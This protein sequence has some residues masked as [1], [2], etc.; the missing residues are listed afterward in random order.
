MPV[1]VASFLVPRN[2]NTWYLVEDTYL[3]GGL[4]LVPNFA[5]LSN[6]HPANL[7]PSMLAITQNDNK[8]WQL[9]PNLT[10]WLEFLAPQNVPV[11]VYTHRQVGASD[12][13]IVEHQKNTRYFTYTVFDSSSR[14]IIP[15][16]VV[17][18][19]EN[20]IFLQFTTPVSG[21][22]TFTFDHTSY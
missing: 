9:Q 5:A 3:K 16:E 19:T 22:S 11:S 10:T 4:R 17:I 18:S 14:Q 20:V 1:P 15:N 8:V 21:H 12:V 13:W 6:I 2:N 7:K